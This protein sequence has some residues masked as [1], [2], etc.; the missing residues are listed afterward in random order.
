MIVFHP[1]RRVTVTNALAHKFVEDYHD[2]QDEPI[3][4]DLILLPHDNSQ[5]RPNDW[6]QIVLTCV[7]GQIMP[8]LSSNT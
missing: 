2:P 4:A 8:P 5:T 1:D 6:K 3:S 7:Q